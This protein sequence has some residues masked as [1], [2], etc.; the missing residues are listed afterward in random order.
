MRT[1]F[2]HRRCGLR[3]VYLVRAALLLILGLAEGCYGADGQAAAPGRPPSAALLQTGLGDVLTSKPATPE[4]AGQAGTGRIRLYWDYHGRVESKRLPVEEARRPD[5]EGVIVAIP[6]A[7][8]EPRHGTFDFSALDTEIE[9][10]AARSRK[11]VI[12]NGVLGTVTTGAHTPPWVYDEGVPAIEFQAKPR[13]EKKVKLPRVWDSP[14]FMVLYEEYVT[15][16]AKRYDGDP[17]VSFVWIGVG[18]LGFTVADASK[19]GMTALPRA[20]WTPEKWTAYIEKVIDLYAG[21]FNKTPTLLGTGPIWTRR[22]R[23]NA[24][25]PQ[26]RHLAVYAASKGTSLLL[27]GLDPDPKVYASTPFSEMLDALGQT[28]LPKGFTLFMG[29]DWPLW[30][31]ER[32]RAQNRHEANRD[33]AG[34]R[35]ALSTA[36]SEWDRLGRKCD[37]VLVLLAPEMQ[38]TTPGVPE[39]RPEVAAILKEFMAQGAREKR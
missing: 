35:A 33:E 9:W 11:V 32:R 27:K 5:L 28:P 17:R 18:H 1:C 22:E 24:I 15:A 3:M 39:Y 25:V 13:D 20:G 2:E 26:M 14:R 31:D 19:G 38:A 36:L 10:W 7:E 6:W 8:I 4:G 34:F 30:V 12:R 23:G 16:L 29:D 21:H 37:F